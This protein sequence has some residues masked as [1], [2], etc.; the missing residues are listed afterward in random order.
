M[1]HTDN[2]HSDNNKTVSVTQVP[3][4]YTYNSVKKIEFLTPIIN[5]KGADEV[6]F[7]T[8]RKI[9]NPTTIVGAE[10]ET[11][12]IVSQETMKIDHSQAEPASG[13][14]IKTLLTYNNTL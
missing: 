10:G 6:D 9:N 12:M 11:P 5:N 2:P 4:T 14:E 13:A 7:S 3:Q 1:I 8:I